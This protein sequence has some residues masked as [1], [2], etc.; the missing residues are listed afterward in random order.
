MEK[1]TEEID[2]TQEDLMR[3][4]IANIIA[5]TRQPNEVT[6]TMVR[7]WFPGL[8]I[9]QAFNKLEQ[10]CDLGLLKKRRIIEDGHTCNAYAPVDGD[11]SD[12]VDQLK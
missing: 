7:K 6:T 2:V 11:W 1:F 3:E 5:G 8:G 10:L 12:I 9:K 4:A